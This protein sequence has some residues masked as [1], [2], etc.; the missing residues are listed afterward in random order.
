MCTGCR[1]AQSFAHNWYRDNGNAKKNSLVL[2]L[3]QG[4]SY[5][6]QSLEIHA[7]IL[8][9]RVYTRAKVSNLAKIARIFVHN[10]LHNNCNEKIIILHNPWTEAFHMVYQS[11]NS[12]KQFRINVCLRM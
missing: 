5:G 12:M 6:T 7:A 10:R 11:H 9:K 1:I 2:F 3:D 4:L 8:E